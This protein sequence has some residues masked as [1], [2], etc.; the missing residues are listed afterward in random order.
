MNW[1]ACMLVL[2][3]AVAARAQATEAGDLVPIEQG[4]VNK[5][6]KGQVDENLSFSRGSGV[7][8]PFRERPSNTYDYSHKKDLISL[9]ARLSKDE[10]GGR[11]NSF[12]S[13]TRVKDALNA[14]DLDRLDTFEKPKP[15][16]EHA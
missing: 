14:H 16:L 5:E 13:G 9:G 3:T 4:D 10:G 1:I 15:L 6:R 8:Q 7:F 2:V 11:A 12:V